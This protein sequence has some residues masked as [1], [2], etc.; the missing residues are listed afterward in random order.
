[1]VF[2]KCHYMS[3]C[4]GVIKPQS[5]G[6]GIWNTAVVNHKNRDKFLGI[7]LEVTHVSWLYIQMVHRF[8]DFALGEN[9]IFKWNIPDT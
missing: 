8:G 9:Q 2:S 1:M 4:Q 5:G 3:F 7:W 6:E